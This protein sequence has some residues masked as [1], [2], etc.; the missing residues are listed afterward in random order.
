L[1]LRSEEVHPS[2]ATQD[3]ALK[4]EIDSNV[5]LPSIES[6]S[7]IAGKPMP[8][9]FTIKQTMTL[10]NCGH[11]TIYKLANQGEITIIKVFGKSLV[12]ELREFIDRKAAEARRLRAAN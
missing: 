2:L 11:T 6:P 1:T 4:M 5:P 10:L 3:E 8:E 7:A 12:L 9:T